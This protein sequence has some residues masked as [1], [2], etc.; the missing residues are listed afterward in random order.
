MTTGFG[1]TTAIDDAAWH[2]RCR[3]DERNATRTKKET[4]ML[5]AISIEALR[6]ITGGKSRA[7]GNNLGPDDRPRQTC[8]P[9]NGGITGGMNV[10]NNKVPC[11]CK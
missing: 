2:P 8:K 3:T 10:T 6:T 1:V 7:N 11:S 5:E 9:G 4:D